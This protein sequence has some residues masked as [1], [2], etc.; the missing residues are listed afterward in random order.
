MSPAASE[1]SNGLE[2][3]HST[4]SGGGLSSGFGSLVASKSGRMLIA[5]V[6]GVDQAGGQSCGRA[7]LPDADLLAAGIKCSMPTTAIV[8]HSN[9]GRD[10][11]GAAPRHDHAY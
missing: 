10:D 7:Q 11:R 6:S 3:E 8:L 5:L 2:V 1:V 9:H 4:N